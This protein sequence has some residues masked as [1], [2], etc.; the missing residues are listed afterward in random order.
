MRSNNI[1]MVCRSE[2]E[3]A[4]ECNTKLNSSENGEFINN[5]KGT[6]KNGIR[7]E[8]RFQMGC[9]KITCPNCDTVHY[10]CN[11]CYSNDGTPTGWY[12]GDSSGETIPC[13]NCNEEEVARQNRH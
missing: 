7:L 10:R 12:V 5:P 3:D 11:M 13:D 6:D 1:E 9:V 8:N 4:S 2:D